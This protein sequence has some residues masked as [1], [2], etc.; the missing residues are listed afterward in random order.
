[1]EACYVIFLCFFYFW[2]QVTNVFNCIGC[3]CYTVYPWNSKSVFLDSINSPT[4]P[5]TEG[6]VDNEWIFI[7]GWTLPLRMDF[8]FVKPVFHRESQSSINEEWNVCVKVQ[9]LMYWLEKFIKDIL[10]LSQMSCRHYRTCSNY[11]GLEKTNK[12]WYWEPCAQCEHSHS[13]AHILPD[14]SA[15]SKSK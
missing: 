1:M 13:S 6:W 14:E 8:G 7:S 3:G 4:S 12:Q 5:S 11:R 10:N 9:I 2:R 15:Q